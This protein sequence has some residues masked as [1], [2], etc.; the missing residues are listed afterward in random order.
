MTE[1]VFK[2]R[3]NIHDLIEIDRILC[4]EG[5][6]PWDM[7]QSHASV[8]MNLVEEAYETVEAIDC[9]DVSMLREE[10]GDVL[11]QVVF[12]S[13]MAVK[14]GEFDFDGVCDGI[15]KKLILRHPHIF[16]DVRVGGSDEVLRNWN[17]IKKD[18]KKQSGRFE[19][20]DSVAKS[21]PALMRG[22]KLFKA[23][24]REGVSR[25]EAEAVLTGRGG[26]SPSDGVASLLWQAVILASEAG[27]DAEQ[28]FKE[29]ADRFVLSQK[30]L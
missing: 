14:D 27:I 1:F 17:E 21:L 2:D 5:G 30:D 8:K 11:Q 19:V 23:A 3:Y 16:G 12:H 29:S 9:G 28:V 25:Q 13:E 4:G 18:E 15:C 10:L 22:Q 6:C 7:E 24:L 20:M 26:G